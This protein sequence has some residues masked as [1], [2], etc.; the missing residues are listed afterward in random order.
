L[1]EVALRTRSEHRDCVEVCEEETRTILLA[2]IQNTALI[3]TIAQW[4]TLR[5]TVKAILPSC[6]RGL[7]GWPGPNG[8]C[9]KKV[10]SHVLFLV[11]AAPTSVSPEGSIHHTST[12]TCFYFMVL[13]LDGYGAALSY[14][15][16]DFI[17][18]SLQQ[19]R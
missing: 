13:S 17:T 19:P 6:V 2:S 9:C 7:R 11:P 4:V 15:L 12:T 3:N 8:S 16:N 14:L 10:P 1:G 5:D 18:L